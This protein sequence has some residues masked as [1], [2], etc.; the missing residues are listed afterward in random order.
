MLYIGMCTCMY[1]VG[2]K[3][4][5]KSLVTPVLDDV[6]K[7][8]VDQVLIFIALDLYSSVDSRDEL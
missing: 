7:L 4:L 2:Y 8:I 1:N 3:R 6:R 5:A